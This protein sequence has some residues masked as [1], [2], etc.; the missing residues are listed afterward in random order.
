M[1]YSYDLKQQQY[2][3]NLERILTAKPLLLGG[4]STAPSGGGTG[5]PPGGFV[6]YLTQRRVSFDETE[7]AVSGIP[8]VSAS[9]IDNLNRIRYRIKTLEESETVGKIDVYENNTIVASGVTSLNFDGDVSISNDGEDK[10]TISINATPSGVDTK[11]IQW[12]AD[13]YLAT[14]SGYGESYV[15]VFWRDFR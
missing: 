9:L 4:P 3:Y 12:F 14:V 13:G 11:T 1:R 5:G 15:T 10:V 7:A 6:G 8:T 2:F